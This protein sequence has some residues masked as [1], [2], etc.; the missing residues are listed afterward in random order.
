MTVNFRARGS[1]GKVAI[2]TGDDDLPLDAPLSHMSRVLFHSDLLYPKIVME[3]SGTLSLP[4]RGAA[5]ISRAAHT[6]FA[7]G[8]AGTPLVI[9]YAVLDG[10]NRPLCGSL[11]VQMTSR[12]FGR[13]LALG[14]TA[15]NV[16]IAETWFSQDNEGFGAISVPWVAYVTDTVI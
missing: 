8:Q 12:G 10:G 5:Q 16:Q 2:F 4:A 6:L 3:V 13:W 9:G 14:A 7:H 1:D 15:S 11:P